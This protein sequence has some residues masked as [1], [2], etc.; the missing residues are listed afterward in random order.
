MNPYLK[1]AVKLPRHNSMYRI[2]A[3]AVFV[4]F[5]FAQAAGDAQI[6]SLLESADKTLPIWMTA[7][8]GLFMVISFL[9]YHYLSVYILEEKLK[10]YGILVSLGKKR[11]ILCRQFFQGL[12]SSLF[13][14]V[15]AGL[16]SGSIV[17]TLAMLLLQRRRF[18]VF[19]RLGVHG[20]L[21]VLSAYLL[22]FLLNMLL[23]RRYFC[24]M[25]IPDMLSCK[26]SEKKLRHPHFCQAA[27]FILLPAGLFLAAVSHSAASYGFLSAFLPMLCLAAG[28]YLLTLSFPFWCFRLMVLREG[29]YHKNLFFISQL[30]TNYH[31]YAKLLTAGTLLI[32]FGIFLLTSDI[33]YAASEDDGALEKPYDI[34]AAID[35]FGEAQAGLEAFEE[36]KETLLQKTRQV[37]M[38][39]GKIPWEGEAYT[40]PV[41]IM[42]ERSYVKLTGKKPGISAGQMYVLSQLDR[43]R[44]T[45][46]TG[47]EGGV[48]WGFQ[49]PGSVSFQVGD[50]IFEKEL[51]KELWEI[52]F[53]L[54]N[55]MQRTYLLNDGDYDALAEST[56]CRGGAYFVNVNDKAALPAV[57]EELSGISGRIEEKTVSL[58]AHARG[59]WIVI[60]IILAVTALLLFSLIGLLLLRI[61]QNR[62]EEKKKY[63]NLYTLGC[64]FPQLLA[65]LKKEMAVLFFLPFFIG[66]PI[67]LCYT[68]LMGMGAAPEGSTAG[69]YEV[70]GYAGMALQTGG[71]LVLAAGV[72]FAVEYI[73]YRIT[74]KLL[75]KEYL[76]AAEP[77]PFSEE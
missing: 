32:I 7:F 64:T 9:Y 19:N 39:E 66:T 2:L 63:L 20:C 31:K 23:L 4:S 1:K 10:D 44:V 51:V 47:V 30:R 73:L 35:D 77:Y 61:Q 58:E 6:T 18:L 21:F 65:E 46:G 48:E 14:S 40:K 37:E 33:R 60:V 36:G 15:L 27:G 68:V 55:Q 38:T 59:K 50:Q 54:E 3:A 17:Y 56:G 71:I 57:L 49:P 29:W 11:Q 5:L 16:L 69:G 45:V 41:L 25:S 75:R 52:V 43:S 74:V 28:A 22:I 8:T 72:F 76:Q 26:R 24:K 70:G 42:P 13:P 67:A 34:A 12:A 62:K 53:N